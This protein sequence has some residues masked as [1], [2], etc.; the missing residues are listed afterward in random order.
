MFVFSNGSIDHLDY[1]EK[2]KQV[3]FTRHSGLMKWE[4]MDLALG[5]YGNNL[6]YLASL[7]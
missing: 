7:R 5:S 2:N 3:A 6:K 1:I 4:H